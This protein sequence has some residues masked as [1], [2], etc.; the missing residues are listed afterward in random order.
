MLLLL[1][2]IPHLTPVLKHV[3]IYLVCTSC[4]ASSHKNECAVASKHTLYL[5]VLFVNNDKIDPKACSWKQDKC[6]AGSL[7]GTSAFPSF[8]IH[9]C[10]P[11][12]F[13]STG[14]RS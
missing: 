4:L 1:S 14:K 10:A 13:V 3:D 9:L 12:A 7:V 8:K 2:E 5:F 6:V 11:Q